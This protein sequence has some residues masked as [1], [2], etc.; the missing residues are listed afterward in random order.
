MRQKRPSRNIIALIALLVF[1]LTGQS[2]VQGYVWCLGEDGHAALEYAEN[3]SCSPEVTAQNH[4]SAEQGIAL[5]DHAQED[6]CG[7]CLDI[8]ATL[9]VTSSRHK[10]D[11]FDLIAPPLAEPTQRWH[12][13]IPQQLVAQKLL[14]QPPPWLS[15][16]LR[17]HRTV[18]LLN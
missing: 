2:G 17:S 1:I 11:Q 9:E 7:P 5:E 3:D 4:C 10:I 16:S 18:V 8:P 15:Q 13:P 14:A 6:H 12:S